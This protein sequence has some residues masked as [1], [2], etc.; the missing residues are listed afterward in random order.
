MCLLCKEITR[1]VV[2]RLNVPLLKQLTPTAGKELRSIKRLAKLLDQFRGDGKELTKALT[3]VYELRLADA[4]LP[5]QDLEDSC[6]LLGISLRDNFVDNGKI[7]IHQVAN[8]LDQI[9]KVINQQSLRR[10]RP[11]KEPQ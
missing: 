2:D 11:D 3:G 5:S 4:H 9:S 8:A 6:D 1:A 10:L 7:I